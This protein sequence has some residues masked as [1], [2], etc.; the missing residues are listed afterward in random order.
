MGRIA[1]RGSVEP[2]AGCIFRLTFGG[3]F[4]IFEKS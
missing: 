1:G 3:V 2:Q 4:T